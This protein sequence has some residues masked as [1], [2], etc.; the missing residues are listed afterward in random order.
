M[1]DGHTLGDG[2]VSCFHFDVYQHIS[3]LMY[4]DNVMLC[5]Q[6]SKN[7]IDNVFNPNYIGLYV[8]PINNYIGK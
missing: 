5:I 7:I 2:W 3:N 8:L 1:F 4:I 6:Q